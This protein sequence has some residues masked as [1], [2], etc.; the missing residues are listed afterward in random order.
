[1][2]EAIVI[3]PATHEDPDTLVSLLETPPSAEG[4]GA[5]ERDRQR[6]GLELMLNNG[7]GRILT[8]S[9]ADRSVVG[10]CSGQ[11]TVSMAKGGPAVLLR[12]MVVLEDWR[13]QGIGELLV[14]PIGRWARE[15]EAGRLQ[16]LADLGRVSLRSGPEDRLSYLP[17]T[18]RG[19]HE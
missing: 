8:A 2:P 11:L 10:L 16:L 1:M 5:V 6:R 9:A 13:G 14:D 18:H 12:D 15:N 3:R 4:H 7:R 19:R 17:G